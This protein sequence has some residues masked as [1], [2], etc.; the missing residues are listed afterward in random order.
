MLILKRI[1]LGPDILAHL[2]S[3]I[4]HLVLGNAIV[5]SLPY[6]KHDC[7]SVYWWKTKILSETPWFHYLVVKKS[8]PIFDNHWQ[9]L[10]IIG[11]QSNLGNQEICFFPLASLSPRS[12]IPEAV[13]REFPAETCRKRTVSGPDCSTWAVLYKCM[14]FS[15]YS[16][17]EWL[18]S[19]HV[20]WLF[21]FQIL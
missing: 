4:R 10:A 18:V 15:T 13:F 17:I 14:T 8:T 12:M 20:E 19:M 16:S 6:Q 2:L 11:N 3:V 9:S 5:A 7:Y 1:K 21:L